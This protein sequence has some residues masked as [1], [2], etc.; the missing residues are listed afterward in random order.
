MKST[1]F[2][3]WFLL[4]GNLKGFFYSI[5]INI[6]LSRHLRNWN[7]WYWEGINAQSFSNTS[8]GI[9][10]KSR[11]SSTFEFYC[12][13]ITKFF[14]VFR[15]GTLGAVRICERGGREGVLSS[16]GQNVKWHFN[17]NSKNH[18]QYYSEITY[19]RSPFD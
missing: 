1:V 13:F 4:F 3:N 2:S 11:G 18:Y 15:G 7:Y 8:E 17:Q 19:A 16:W 5:T 14:E 12:I 9:V 6:F 10:R